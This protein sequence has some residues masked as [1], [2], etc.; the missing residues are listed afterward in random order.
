MGVE[1]VRKPV[2]ALGYNVA[3]TCLGTGVFVSLFVAVELMV[4]ATQVP[5]SHKTEGAGYHQR[6]SH[7]FF[8]FSLQYAELIEKVPSNTYP[9]PRVSSSWRLLTVA[10]STHLCSSGG[11][12]EGGPTDI[13]CPPDHFACTSWQ[14]GPLLST[15]QHYY[16]P[17]N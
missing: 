2:C 17:R 10:L 8:V 9:P 16:D 3:S 15:I 7:G 14:R 11:T 13:R 1:S 6:T 5:L 4:K 12:T